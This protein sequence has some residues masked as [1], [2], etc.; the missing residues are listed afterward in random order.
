MI[1]SGCGAS[2]R[3]GYPNRWIKVC[4]GSPRLMTRLLVLVHD[5]AACDALKT[6]LEMDGFEVRATNSSGAAL[7]YLANERFVAVIVDV[8]MP[9][10]GVALIRALRAAAPN[11]PI[12]VISSYLASTDTRA[13]AS[14]G[15]ERILTRPLNYERLMNYLRQCL[16]A[17]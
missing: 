1:A 15:L 17:K 14:Y 2:R 3:Q 13:A 10:Q 7:S 9:G 11:L 6:L 4:F 16:E 5:V 12:F 8:D